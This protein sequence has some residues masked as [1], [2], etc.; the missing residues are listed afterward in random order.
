MQTAEL[1]CLSTARLGSEQG[2]GPGKKKML[3]TFQQKEEANSENSPCTGMG[4]V[5]EGTQRED[6]RETFYS[7]ASLHQGE[8][9]RLPLN[10]RI[11]MAS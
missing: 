4:L 8:S 5:A 1:Q 9:I 7:M 3:R 2:T 6:N 11:H 10:I